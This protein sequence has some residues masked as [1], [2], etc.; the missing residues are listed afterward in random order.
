[1][2]YISQIEQQIHTLIT[3]G[4]IYIAFTVIA[5]VVIFFIGCEILSRL[6]QIKRNIEE[7][8]DVTAD[9]IRATAE[10]TEMIEK[11]TSK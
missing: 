9:G 4:K 2:D 1:M 8:Q 6:S 7:L 10:I 11:T 3:C 5:L